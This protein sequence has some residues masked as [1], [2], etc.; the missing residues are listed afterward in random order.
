M[1]KL[2]LN[3]RVKEKINMY[4]C[5]YNLE[6]L[7][8]ATAKTSFQ[9]YNEPINPK[10]PANYVRQLKNTD[11]DALMICPTAWKRPLWDSKVDPH[12][13]EEAVNI[14][15]PYLTTDLKYHE[16]AYFRLK[17][18][19][20]AGNDPVGVTIET[21]K[22]LGIAPFISYRMNDHHYLHQENAF[23]HPS[24]WRDNPQFWL[25]SGSIQSDGMHNSYSEDNRHFDYMHEEVRDYYF[26]LLS[27][28]AWKYDIAGIELDFM[29]SPTYFKV[30]DLDRGREIM[31]S[32]VR[33]IRDLLDAV[34]R[35]RGKRLS[36][37]VRVP[38]T[39]KWSYELG[40]DIERWDKEKIIDMIN[41]STYF[42]NSPEIDVN[43]YKAVVKNAALYG[44]MHFIID[45]IQLPNGFAN[46][47]TRKTT[48]EMYRALAATFLDRGLDGISFFN[49]D[50][51]RHHFFNE[52]RRNH[53]PDSEPPL[54]E[55]EGITD[56]SH[57]S[58]LDKHYFI[59]PYYSNL[60]MVNKL[61]QDLYIADQ[62]ITD[63]FKHAILRIKTER[64]CMGINIE[65]SVNGQRLEEI[66]WMGELFPPLSIEGITAPEYVK[67]YKVPIN[68]LRHGYNH[69][70]AV[71]LSDDPTLWDKSAV[72]NMIELAIYRDNSF[73]ID[74]PN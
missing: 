13:T 14:K 4:K 72:F 16:K 69:I 40:L 63:K 20:L 39:T 11:V 21:A 68:I 26:S 32:F 38:Y 57:L 7:I 22:E 28:L 65:T 73:L 18:Y 41:L 23:I 45:K 61:E 67:Y 1:E 35:A 71:N 15:Q 36:L 54:N 59:G 12:W 53:M 64:A 58:S 29:R 9:D 19:M 62:D 43:G 3:R 27:E 60:P 46:N 50:Y 48:K 6:L 70:S 24:F 66:V 74:N 2:A 51:A 34:G 8:L 17:D 49:V 52:P 5:L 30:A 37:C 47:C 56:L 55:F 33:R 42:I 44:E 10:T 31:T 25:G